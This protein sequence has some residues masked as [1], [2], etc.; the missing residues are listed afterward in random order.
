MDGWM[1]VSSSLITW[2]VEE[3]LIELSFAMTYKLFTVTNFSQL[4]KSLTA[5]LLYNAVLLWQINILFA[6]ISWSTKTGQKLNMA[7]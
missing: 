1:D 6:V 2:L 7:I 5:V 3:D 4:G